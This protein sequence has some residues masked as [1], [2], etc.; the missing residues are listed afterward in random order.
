MGIPGCK[1]YGEDMGSA[2]QDAK[3][4]IAKIETNKFDETDV[5][6]LVAANEVLVKYALAHKDEH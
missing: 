6:K 5:L 1:Y 4:V 3:K 2:I